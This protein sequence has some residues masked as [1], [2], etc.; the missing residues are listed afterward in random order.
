MA[1]ELKPCPFCGNNAK[2]R[3]FES[4]I[5]KRTKVWYIECVVCGNQTK[6]QLEL[7]HAADKWNRRDRDGNAT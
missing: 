3:R 1:T 4:G 7:E 2:A 6:V 5:F